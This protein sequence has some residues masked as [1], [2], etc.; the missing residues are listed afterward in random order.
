LAS[1]EDWAAN[2][3]QKHVEAIWVSFGRS[4][5]EHDCRN[6]PSDVKGKTL[7]VNFHNQVP[8][9]TVYPSARKSSV[10]SF[11]I[12]AAA[13]K[14]IGFKCS[15]SS[16]INRTPYFLTTQADFVT[17][18]VV[19]ESVIDGNAGHSD[20]NTWFGGIAFRIEPQDGNMFGDLIVQQNHVN[21]VVE[22][23]FFRLPFASLFQCPAYITFALAERIRCDISGT[24]LRLQCER[25]W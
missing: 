5:N 2:P 12:C 14:G 18:F 15:N 25:V 10:K 4:G 17:V 16:G 7:A 11:S 23:W 19:F 24:A 22:Y 9:V 3:S 20:I 1:R 21:T 6:Q 13:S 8:P